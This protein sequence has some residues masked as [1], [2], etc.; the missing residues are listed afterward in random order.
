[1]ASGNAIV[2]DS[3]RRLMKV[4]EETGGK[5]LQIKDQLDDETRKNVFE[6]NKILLVRKLD[7]TREKINERDEAMKK[8]KNN[9]RVIKLNQNIKKMLRY[10]RKD[11]QHLE[12]IHKNAAKKKFFGKQADPRELAQ[13]QEDLK[14]LNLHVTQVEKLDKRRF[15]NG[16]E[17][18]DSKE[19]SKRKELFSI[20]EEDNTPS[21]SKPLI[22]EFLLNEEDLPQ[23]ARD[24]GNLPRI[25]IEESL[26]QVQM[27]K[28]QMD[29]GL[30]AFSKKIEK[31]KHITDDI[32][33]ELD[34]QNKLLENIGDKVDNELER[35]KNLNERTEKANKLA[36]Q[37]TK[38]CLIMLA[39]SIITVIVGG[40]A[41]WLV[42]FF[43]PK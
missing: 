24:Y 2:L 4:Y 37:S 10:L 12:S 22:S 3:M 40:V 25:N 43:T 38:I 33:S 1:M 18:L 42:Y 21:Q 6:A 5:E 9:T 41:V 13:Q 27:Y 36:N 7:L 23:D 31:L 39:V 26:T 14:L 16:G 28:K 32:G 11:Y 35:L 29:Q 19:A 15:E 30:D 34:E 20:N 8:N 17:P